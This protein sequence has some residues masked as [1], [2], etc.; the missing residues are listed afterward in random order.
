MIRRE[1]HSREALVYSVLCTLGWAIAVTAPLLM[2][3]G[4]PDRQ[5][6]DPTPTIEPPSEDRSGGAHHLPDPESFDLRTTTDTEVRRLR[7]GLNFELLDASIDHALAEAS[8]NRH[9]TAHEARIEQR[10]HALNT[11]SHLERVSTDT[12]ISGFMAESSVRATLRPG[13]TIDA[14]AG[15]TLMS[16]A[17]EQLTTQRAQAADRLQEAQLA[18][19]DA[20]RSL[21]RARAQHHQSS[22]ELQSIRPKLKAFDQRAAEHERVATETDRVA[23]A[24][25]NDVEL[26]AVASTLTVNRTIEADIDRLIAD[27]RLDGLDLNGGG[28]RTVEEQIGLR[29]A[30]CDQSHEPGDVHPEPLAATDLSTHHRYVIFEVPSSSCS[31]PTA[32]PGE[33]EHQ[34]GLALDLTNAGELLTIASPAYRWLA[35]NGHA[36]GLINLPGEP[37]HWS[38]TGH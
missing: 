12:A 33:S 4:G 28:F 37:W 1:A 14:L 30:N 15:Q 29:L 22:R 25:S 3:L 34:T 26:R 10:Q 7:S 13:S 36:Y 24:R 6:G 16:Y 19:Q 11:L 20:E 38:T 31:P 5:Q 32:P 27:A 18:V 21:R 35:E 8:L 23:A 9:E 17:T 2:P